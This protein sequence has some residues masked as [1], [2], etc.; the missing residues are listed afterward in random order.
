[1]T[2]LGDPKPGREV[3]WI[4]E[5]GILRAD[6]GEGRTVE[7]TVESSLVRWVV[8]VR[9]GGKQVAYA[10]GAGVTSSLAGFRLWTN[11]DA[12]KPLPFPYKLTLAFEKLELEA[13]IGYP[14]TVRRPDST[15]LLSCSSA[16]KDSQVK[17]GVKWV[18][19]VISEELPWPEAGLAAGLA[20]WAD[21]IYRNMAERQ[22]A[23][24]RGDGDGPNLGI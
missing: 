3:L 9:A 13:V 4:D 11:Y 1:M 8:T 6:F 23:T 19:R 22:Y 20:L 5:G 15:V 18:T 10:Y 21:I 14:H 17:Q 12:F 2:T 7:A 16:W 24:R